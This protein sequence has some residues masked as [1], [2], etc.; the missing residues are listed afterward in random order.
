MGVGNKKYVGDS[1][2]K[3]LCDTLDVSS[4]KKVSRMTQ[5]FLV[6]ANGRNIPT[7]ENEKTWRE[8]GFIDKS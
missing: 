1:L 4:E 2:S 3:G 5:K 6:W 7:N 8:V